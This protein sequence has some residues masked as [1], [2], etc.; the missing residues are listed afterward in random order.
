MTTHTF[1]ISPADR[2]QYF[3]SPCRLRQVTD[4]LRILLQ[5]TI[6][7]DGYEYEL[8]PE[9]TQPSIFQDEYSGRVHFHGY[10]KL[11]D[12]QKAMFYLNHSKP[13]SKDNRIEI[14]SIEDIDKWNKYVTKQRDTMYP[15][16]DQY[17]TPYVI[18]NDLPYIKEITQIKPN[19]KNVI[20]NQHNRVSKGEKEV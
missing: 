16:C 1:T 4:R 18:N 20:N 10:I 14:D 7:N 9:I 5:N 12:Q 15:I 17:H 6:Q 11:S 2:V 8:Y 13:L 3:G 19:I